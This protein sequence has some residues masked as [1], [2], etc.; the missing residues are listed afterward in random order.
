MYLL[1]LNYKLFLLFYIQRNETLLPFVDGHAI[2]E[3]EEAAD[4]KQA[5]P[6]TY[7][8]LELGI[9]GQQDMT[10]GTK[11]TGDNATDITNGAMLCT[12]DVSITHQGEMIAIDSNDA[13]QHEMSW[14]DLCQ[15]GI[16]NIERCTR[17]KLHTIT[18]V[19][20]EGTHGIALDIDNNGLTV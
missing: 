9:A 13:M 12:T 10:I 19:F 1:L 8:T 7:P 20:Q 14:S 5:T 4:G 3:Q 16:T 18:Q 11:I 17:S 6:K 15:Y 2:R